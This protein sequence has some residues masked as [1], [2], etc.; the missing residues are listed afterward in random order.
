[1]NMTS[2]KKDKQLW[3]TIQKRA[4]AIGRGAITLALTSYYCLQD[5][6]TPAWARATIAAALGYLVLPVDAVPD[7]LPGGLVD[8]AAVLAGA[9]GTVAAHIKLQHR[10]KAAEQLAVL[11]G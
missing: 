6:D 5:S 1:M 11:L 4:S 2:E 10:K 9:C 7:I 8:D 3:S